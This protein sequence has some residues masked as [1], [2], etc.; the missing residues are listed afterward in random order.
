[1][2]TIPDARLD[3]VNGRTQTEIDR[4]VANSLRGD[5]EAS[6]EQ[7]QAASMFLCWPMNMIELAKKDETLPEFVAELAKFIARREA[8][9]L[10]AAS[11]RIR[12]LEAERDNEV[13]LIWSHE[14]SAWWRPKRCGYTTHLKS[15]GRYPKDEALRICVSAHDG[16][17]EGK[18]P[19]EIPVREQ[20]ALTVSEL[21]HVKT[22]AICAAL[23]HA[24]PERSGG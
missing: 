10:A 11:E 24:E 14:H 19:P 13:Y 6:A 7:R 16:W 5:A 23:S 3:D 20:D 8:I 18:P 21:H 1:V 4:L 2:T 12:V 15:A 9:A 17:S 22:T